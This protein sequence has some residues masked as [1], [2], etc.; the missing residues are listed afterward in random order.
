MTPT[1]AHSVNLHRYSAEWKCLPGR[2][3]IR[4]LSE[5]A[6]SSAFPVPPSPLLS[7]KQRTYQEW[8]EEYL[9]T[10]RTSEPWT[11]IIP[12]HGP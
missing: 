10:D 3:P 5:D 4:L 1:A 11:S 2:E 6:Q 9:R 8:N 7:H 12:P